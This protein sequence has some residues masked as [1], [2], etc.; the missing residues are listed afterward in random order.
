VVGDITVQVKTTDSISNEK[1]L[2]V[3][4]PRIDRLET[5][6]GDVLAGAGSFRLWISG[7][8]F[9]DGAEVELDGVTVPAGR[10]R[11]TGKTLIRVV[12]KEREAQKSGKMRVV[13]RN[14]GGNPSDPSLLDVHGPQIDALAP[15]PVVAGTSDVAVD[16]RG[17]FFR[18]HA[19]VTLTDSTGR[20]FELN[21]TRVRFRSAQRV[22]V[23]LKRELNALVEQPGKELSVRLINPNLTTGVPSEPVALA[24]AGPQI[25]D[26]VLDPVSN[27]PSLRRLVIRGSS[28]R[29]RAEVEFLR[30]GMAFARLVPEVADD[31]DSPRRRPGK[32]S[33]V[34]LVVIITA[35]KLE[36]WGSDLQV[37]VVNPGEIKSDPVRPRHS[38]PTP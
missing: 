21:H 11:Q 14:P 24:V 28:F 35:A 29:N 16:I 33:A 34:R 12:V 15:S 7:T 30:A 22:T 26:A 1:L 4:G 6:M 17:S 5:S 37:R 9:R 2:A 3:F 31:D 10:V 32:S 18:R 27:D 38:E 23:V 36:K 8:N 19:S 20:T 25:T 13:V